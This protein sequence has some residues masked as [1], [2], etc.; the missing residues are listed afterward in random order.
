MNTIAQLPNFSRLDLDTFPQKLA[1]LLA[2]NL[3]KLQDIL[4][5]DTHTWDSLIQPQEAMHQAVQMLWA[6]VS[7]LHSVADTPPIRAAYKSGLKQLSDYHLAMMQNVDLYRAISTLAEQATF[8]QYTAAQQKVIQNMLRDFKLS[9]VNLPDA[10]KKQFLA[11]KQRLS[12]LCAKFSENLLDAT[13]AWTYHVTDAKMLAGLP[14]RTMDAAK[15]AALKKQVSGWL[16]T[17][18]QP[19]YVA[20]MTYA[21]SEALR[22]KMYYAYTTR[23][24]DVG[25]HAGKWDNTSVMNEILQVRQEIAH[26]LG[27]ENYA[28]YALQT[29]MIKHTKTVFAFLADL[30]QASLQKA[31]KEA[32]D[33][34]AFA[35]EQDSVSRLNAW[36]IAYYSEKLRQHAYDVS[37]EMLRPY[38]PVNQVVSGLFLLLHRL[39]GVSFEEV[40]GIAI[41][42]DSVRVFAL[43]VAH[44]GHK[45]SKG[46]LYLDLYARSG[47]KGGAWMHDAF[48]RFQLP[49]GTVQL[50]TGFVVCNFNAPVGDA[51]ALLSHGDVQT[52][53]H[54]CGHA[55][56]H[57]L[58]TVN[59]PFV[60]GIEGVPWDAVEIASQLMENWCWQKEGLDAVAKHY[61]TGEG[62]PDA[63]FQKLLQ[64]KHFQAGM[65]MVRQLT[66]AQF[67]FLIHT[68]DTAGKPGQ[69]AAVLQKVRQELFVYDVPAF[70]RFQHG[71]SHIFAGG[72]A[73]GY[74]SYKWA[75]AL[76]CDIF[77]RFEEAGIFN[78]TVGKHFMHTFLEKGGSI[79]PEVLFQDFMGRAPDM[80]ALLKY[81]GILQN[82]T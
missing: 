16:L 56:Q 76:A 45:I 59:H 41:W 42:D 78:S 61:E 80:D 18:E 53:F 2:H 27:F 48:A 14:Q 15:Q 82:A 8:A 36:D 34:L 81:T 43:S 72:Y 13:Q 73:A 79:D 69:I 63:L 37:E 32:A 9:G 31:Q 68:S 25:P 64:A 10:Q 35:K 28:H 7:H 70:N 62:L 50:P 22:Q 71:F 52:L 12:Q 6:K 40:T 46:Y 3:E 75:E 58:T 55:L 33:L 4:K 44:K 57:L 5:Q 23:A 77:S 29:R 1:D 19:C 11:C 47:K 74:Y 39:Y 51:P 49:V 67:D 65:H 21:A 30:G 38:F 20:V 26:L 17:L 24:S 60:A 54:E 66:F